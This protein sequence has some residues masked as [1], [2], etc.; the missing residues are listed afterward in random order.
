MP[1]GRERFLFKRIGLSGKGVLKRLCKKTEDAL[2]MDTCSCF[3]AECDFRD[4]EKQKC[5]AAGLALLHIS[6][7]HRR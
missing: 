2:P 5:R 6:E 1:G 3:L 4:T 7:P